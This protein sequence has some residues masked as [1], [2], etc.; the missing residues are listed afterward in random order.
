M[1][2]LVSVSTF[3][4]DRERPSITGERSAPSSIFGAILT[5][6]F[7]SRANSAT[8]PAGGCTHVDYLS[9]YGLNEQ[10]FLIAPTPRFLYMSAQHKA[11]LSKVVSRLQTRQG[12]SIIYGAVGTGKTTIARWLYDRLNDDPTGLYRVR[13]IYNPAFRRE[14][15]LLRVILREFGVEELARTLDG[16]LA[17]LQYYLQR[18]VIEQDRTVVLIIDE[19]NLL[20]AA[21]LE[22]LR[23][24][25]NFEN[26]EFKLLQ[27]VLVG[28][29]DLRAKVHR[30]PALASR[31]RSVSTLEPFDDDELTRMIAFR[32]SVAGR[33][34]PLFSPEALHML[35]VASEGVPR[36]A[37]NLAEYAVVAAY[38]EEATLV[39]ASHVK[40]ATGEVD[41]GV[42]LERSA[43][44]MLAGT[45]G[46]Q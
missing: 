1:L 28:T 43:R 29:D 41:Y 46:R 35:Y 15:Q 3:Q 2:S 32:L 4:S 11:A 23:Q 44:P 9:F 42:T 5:T 26:N 12:L 22:F 25:L 6:I 45:G 33:E 8:L 17:I 37:M 27:I 10:P 36:T 16:N 13:T 31:V 21:L 14:N 34:R 18:E 19:A 7:H 39:E 38:A 40:T 24:L 20:P 30:K